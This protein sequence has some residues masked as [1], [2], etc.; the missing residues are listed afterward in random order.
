MIS[1]WSSSGSSFQKAGA[2]AFSFTCAFQRRATGTVG[3]DP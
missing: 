2:L 1:L 3:A